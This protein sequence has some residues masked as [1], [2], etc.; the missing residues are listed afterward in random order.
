VQPQG[1]CRDPY[2]NHDERWFSGGQPTNLVR[3]QGTESYDEPPQE[4]LLP[5]PHSSP[6]DEELPSA[7][8]GREWR[9]WR[10]WTV[11]LPGLLAIAVWF[12]FLLWFAFLPEILALTL[13]VAGLC[14][15]GWR[16]TIAV[17][18]WGAFALS[19][20]LV[21]LAIHSLQSID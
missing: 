1:W 19:C 15:P 3:D 14:W 20:Y 11:V 9:P 2:G 8:A 21:P 12:V 10:W 13:L 4:R 16:R 17:T 6:P 7:R 18:L 5:S